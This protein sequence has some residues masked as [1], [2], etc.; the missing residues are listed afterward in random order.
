MTRYRIVAVLTDGS[1]REH[2]PYQNVYV[3][4]GAAKMLLDLNPDVQRVY[5]C[6]VN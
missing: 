2:G 6:C 3:A 1:T 4:D 5:F